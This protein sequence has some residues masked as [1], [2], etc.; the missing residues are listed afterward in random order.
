MPKKLI[1]VFLLSLYSGVLLLNCAGC[2]FIYGLLQREGA[3][4][5]EILGPIDPLE[6][7]DKVKELQKLLKLYGYRVGN[8]D[9]KMGSLTR[10]AI[11]Q[12]QEDQDL[13]VSRFVDRATWEKLNY[14]VDLGLITNGELDVLTI[15]KVLK[16]AG[17]DPGK[18][19]GKTGQKTKQAVVQFQKKHGLKAD[20]TIGVKTLNQMAEYLE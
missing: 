13:K 6:S 2:D 19:D 17:C 15:Q 5:K 10:Q 14:F 16:E 3:E 11:A 8:A 4:E 20:G 9:G 1:P 12:Y 7:N 18:I